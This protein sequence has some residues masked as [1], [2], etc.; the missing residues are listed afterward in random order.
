[1]VA[2]PFCRCRV[3][4]I[5]SAVPTITKDGL[6]GI[7]QPLRERYPIGGNIDTKGI[8][9]WL[10]V[11]SNGL[12]L[13]YIDGDKR[14]ETAF[15]PINSLHYCAAVRYVNVTGYAIEGGGER[16]LPLDSPFA[17]GEDNQHP[18]IFAAIFR[19][20]TG[21][22]VLECHAFICT[23][24]KAAN[25]LVR[26]CFHAYAESMYIKLDERLPALKSIKE[27]SRSAS[28]P[29]EPLPSEIEE[30]AA[31]EDDKELDQQR[32]AER[33]IGKEAW[34]RRQQS[35]EYDSASISSSIANRF[36]IKKQE[37][38]RT[39]GDQALVPY[40]NGTDSFSQRA[41]SEIGMVCGDS[42]GETPCP[43]MYPGMLP[44]HFR[45]GSLP[46][47]HMIPAHPL[48]RPPLFVPF[49]PPP[50]PPPHLLPPM[51]RF[52]PMMGAPPPANFGMPPHLPPGIYPLPPPHFGILPPRFM[53]PY[54]PIPS[55]MGRPRTPPDG[56]IITG[57]E[58]VYGTLPRRPAYEEPIYMP[59]SA[60]YM[61]P[62]ASYQPG[63]YLTDQYDAY[64]DSLKRQRSPH[65]NNKG[66]AGG[67]ESQTSS[68]RAVATTENDDSSQFWDSYEASIYRKPHLNE[69][70]FSATARSMPTATTVITTNHNHSNTNSINHQ[71]TATKTTTTTATTT[72]TTTTT[73]LGIGTMIRETVDIVARPKTP[74]A[75]Y[76]TAFSEMHISNNTSNNNN[77]NKHQR[78][79]AVIY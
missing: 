32:W 63:N 61:P 15:H 44:P 30:I 29:S 60:P 50:P 1:M 79:T 9:S 23:N 59:G 6:Q 69:K 72:T 18:P 10:S 7:Q 17:T 48:I 37:R 12:L 22:K 74:P 70:A 57:P 5:G 21:I 14:T 54:G 55:S 49:P 75:D 46:L 38:D 52:M 42:S 24:A 11:W 26:C 58:S 8:D 62:Q 66:S 25:A 20:T 47:S 33:A 27:A 19:R 39:N 53:T 56:P 36:R 73:G 31:I 2:V 71:S 45:G 34:E 28:P 64:Y 35:G 4:Y 43:G 78:T 41:G 40:A 16:F 76:D 51:H 68:R 67:A 13:E 77:N 3:L 65:Q